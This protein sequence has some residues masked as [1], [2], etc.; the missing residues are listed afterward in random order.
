MRILTQEFAKVF[1]IID[2]L[3]E[4]AETSWDIIL[5]IVACLQ[6]CGANVLIT[7][8]DHVY[9]SISHSSLAGVK[10]VDIHGHTDD[11]TRYVDACLL[12]HKRLAKFIQTD[13][14]LHQEIVTA[15]TD[16]CQGM[17]VS[18]I[19]ISCVSYR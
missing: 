5:K 4:C 14:S 1:I 10:R 9:D 15:V 3:D 11:I 19:Q 17:Y 2:A 18:F 13:L 16:S 6:E 12:L 7:S 8:R